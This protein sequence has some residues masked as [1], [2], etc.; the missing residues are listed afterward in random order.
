MD[1][2]V[3]SQLRHSNCRSQICGKGLVQLQFMTFLNI[4]PWWINITL[5]WESYSAITWCKEEMKD[6][7]RSKEKVAYN[8]CSQICSICQTWCIA[9]TSTTLARQLLFKYS[10]IINTWLSSTSRCWIM[11]CLNTRK[12]CFKTET[13][14]SSKSCSS[15]NKPCNHSNTNSCYS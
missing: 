6:A 15:I 14:N 9:R 8:L 13:S 1:G 5:Q 11:Q 7:T 12:R 3:T 4:K 10:I 2:V